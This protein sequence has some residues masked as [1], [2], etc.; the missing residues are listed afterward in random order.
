[1]ATRTEVAAPCSGILPRH[2]LRA[3]ELLVEALEVAVSLVA[4]QVGANTAGVYGVG[5]DPVAGP[6]WGRRRG[7]PTR[8]GGATEGLG[9]GSR[10]K[11]PCTCVGSR[12]RCRFRCCRA[13]ELSVSHRSV[14]GFLPTYLSFSSAMRRADG[15]R[16][17]PRIPQDR[18]MILTKICATLL[19]S[20]ERLRA[21]QIGS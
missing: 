19:M 5:G 15:Y 10:L 8:T 1:V 9:R 21:A 18:L 13:A 17:A 12:H 14:V 6:A 2:V 16:D 3:A 20:A 11:V 7:G 4:H